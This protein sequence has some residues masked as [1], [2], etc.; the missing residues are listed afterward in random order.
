MQSSS[1]SFHFS[2][3]GRIEVASTLEYNLHPDF[4]AGYQKIHSA[5][6]NFSLN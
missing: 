4:R 6:A 5:Q 1:V 2:D 3:H